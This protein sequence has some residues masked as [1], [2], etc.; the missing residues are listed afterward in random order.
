MLFRSEWVQ[1]LADMTKELRLMRKAQE[2]VATECAKISKSVAYLV[3]DLDL[4]VEGKR[5]VRTRLHGPVIGE[6]ES[7]SAFGAKV[8]KPEAEKSKDAV[9]ED[10]T[11]KE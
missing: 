4:I 10:M 11:M 9:D 8:V 7:P 5:Y 6:E 2:K 3:T 1:S